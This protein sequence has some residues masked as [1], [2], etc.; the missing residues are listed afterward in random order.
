MSE[1]IDFVA[2]GIKAFEEDE[3][4]RYFENRE[5]KGIPQCEKDLFF[6][7]TQSSGIFSEDGVLTHWEDLYRQEMEE[8]HRANNLFFLIAGAT[9]DL[10]MRIDTR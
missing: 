4:R 9:A 6:R 8:I 10:G 7:V 1:K 5:E 2:K 3:I